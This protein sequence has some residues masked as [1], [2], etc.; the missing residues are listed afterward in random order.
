MDERNY[1]YDNLDRLTQNGTIC[2]ILGTTHITEFY[3]TNEN[4]VESI[5]EIKTH[6]TGLNRRKIRIIY[7]NNIRLKSMILYLTKKQYR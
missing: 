3:Y 5:S 4:L 2:N 1:N 7:D 6:K